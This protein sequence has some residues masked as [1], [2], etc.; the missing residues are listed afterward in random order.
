MFKLEIYSKRTLNSIPPFQ[1]P[2]RR[3][4]RPGAEPKAMNGQSTWM[5]SGGASNG[6]ARGSS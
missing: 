1:G 2:A 5:I 4:E 6:P 3:A